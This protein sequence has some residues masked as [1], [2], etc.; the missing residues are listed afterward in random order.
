MEWE[1]RLQENF[2]QTETSCL[3]GKS[4]ISWRRVEENQNQ[5]FFGWR[6][7]PNQSKRRSSTPPPQEPLKGRNPREETNLPK[8]PKTHTSGPKETD[9][10]PRTQEGRR[11]RTIIWSPDNQNKLSLGRLGTQPGETPN[12]LPENPQTE[13]FST[14]TRGPEAKGKETFPYS[15]LRTERPHLYSSLTKMEEGRKK[16]LQR[17][18]RRM[19]GKKV[20]K[21]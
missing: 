4:E 8:N 18:M 6:E 7:P 9:S 3:G 17:I 13:D 19:L 16:L 1:K 5:G 14:E 2:N 11:G 12:Y 20:S 21:S 10:R 15:F